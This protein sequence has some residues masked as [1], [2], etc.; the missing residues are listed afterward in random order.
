MYSRSERRLP[1]AT[2]RSAA[3]P[4]PRSEISSSPNVRAMRRSSGTPS[5]FASNAPAA[6]AVERSALFVREQRARRGLQHAEVTLGRLGRPPSEH[7]PGELLAFGYLGVGNELHP[8]RARVAR[9]LDADLDL[10]LAAPRRD[11][12]RRILERSVEDD[13]AWIDLQRLAVRE[14]SGVQGFDAAVGTQL[15]ILRRLHLQLAPDLALEPEATHLE[16]V[17]EVELQ[18]EPHRNLGGLARGGG[19][20]ADDHHILAELRHAALVQLDVAAVGAQRPAE[21]EAFLDDLRF[22]AP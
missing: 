13:H 6:A 12:Q 19:L 18:I 3:S 11:L 16:L 4:V 20:L 14:E 7:Q 15:P 8:R 22:A 1:T 10:L 5:L 2:T 17:T 21:R 9:D